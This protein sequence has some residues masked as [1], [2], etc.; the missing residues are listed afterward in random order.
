[1]SDETP[2]RAPGSP[3]ATATSETATSA[4][5]LVWTSASMKGGTA[6][7][8]KISDTAVSLLSTSP[9]PPGSRIDATFVEATEVPF[10]VKIHGSKK[11][12]DGLFALEGRPIDMT[13]E[14]RMRAAALVLATQ[15]PHDD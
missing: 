1:M 13:R 11:R 8:V 2:D 3:A 7:F 10:R 4:T 15:A 12:P 9:S 6:R 5:H 14:V